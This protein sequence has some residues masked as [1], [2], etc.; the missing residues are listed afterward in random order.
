M[1]F[2]VRESEGFTLVEFELDGPIEPSALKTLKPPEVNPR[3]GVVLSGRGPIWLYGFLLHHYHPVR[4]IGVYD[5]RLGAV[6]VQ[7][8]D[9]NK[10][11]GDIIE[12]ER[13]A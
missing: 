13:R 10:G 6:V 9:P 7:S 3:K 1:K 5:P 8:H 2:Q 4:W 12:I 11:I